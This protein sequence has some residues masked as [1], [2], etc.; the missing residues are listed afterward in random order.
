MSREA[1]FFAYHCRYFFRSGAI[2]ATILF[3]LASSLFSLYVSEFASYH[4]TYGAV[5][6]VVVLLFWFY[7]SSFVVLLGAELS[8]TLEGEKLRTGRTDAPPASPQPD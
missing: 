1:Y 2:I 8:A 7:Y 6:S 3:L 5:G 4:K